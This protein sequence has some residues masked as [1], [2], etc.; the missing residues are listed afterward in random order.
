MIDVTAARRIA[1]GDGPI[2]ILH[3]AGTAVGQHYDEAVAVVPAAD[4]L[5]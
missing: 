1:A 3:N 2:S 4:A 5:H